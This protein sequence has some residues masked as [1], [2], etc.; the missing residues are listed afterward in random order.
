MA[1]CFFV[2]D[3]HG[4]V[5]RY[6]ALFARIRAERPRGVFLGGDLLPSTLRSL[7]GPTIVHRDFVGE[8]LA[9]AFLALGE[10]LGGE[11]P[12][13]FLVLGNDDARADEAAVVEAA[14][15]GAWHYAHFRR[16]PFEGFDVLGYSFVP[17]T[18]F[19]NKDWERY[20]VSRFVDPGCVSPEEG[21][22][23]VPVPRRETRW[24][25]IQRDLEE[26]TDGSDLSRTICLFHSPPY[27]TPLDRAALDGRVVDH[28]PVDVHVGSIAIRRFIEAR[29]PRITLHGHIHESARL[30]G[31]WRC[32]I[33]TTEAMSAAHDGPELALVRFDPDLPEEATRELIGPAVGNGS[34]GR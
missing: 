23:T 16:Q 21:R 30:T 9:P 8:F 18:P 33:G 29:G 22:R 13:V 7:T 15:R 4:D 19:L 14:A 1:A 12:E 27:R 24:S 25:T 26:L 20:D 28:A 11:R 2:T 34:G 32:R 3:L 5:D 17:P 10:E 31:A 6:E